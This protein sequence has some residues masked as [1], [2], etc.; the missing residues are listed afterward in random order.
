MEFLVDICRTTS[1]SGEVEYTVDAFRFTGS[2]IEVLRR[3][4]CRDGTSGSAIS[5]GS[6]SSG[7][8]KENV[9]SDCAVGCQ[10]TREGLRS[11]ALRSIGG[12]SSC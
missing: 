11:V 8:T 9:L 5:S 10:L 1:G 4:G 3:V 7:E 12:C 6:L 2:A